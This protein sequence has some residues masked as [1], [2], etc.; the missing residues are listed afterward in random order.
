MLLSDS[1]VRSEYFS[2]ILKSWNSIAGI[3][4][5]EAILMEIYQEITGRTAGRKIGKINILGS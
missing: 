2:L 4:F 1:V 5:A 3:V